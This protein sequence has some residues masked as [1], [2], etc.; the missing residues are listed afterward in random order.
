[1]T[2]RLAIDVSVEKETQWIGS[3]W[4]DRYPCSGKK[5]TRV[6]F[7]KSVSGQM[8]GDAYPDDTTL[9][10]VNVHCWAE[11]FTKVAYTL[12]VWVED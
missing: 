6:E 4:D 1:M 12:R 2:E 9:P 11:S 7:I 8:R 3:R 10:D 5:I